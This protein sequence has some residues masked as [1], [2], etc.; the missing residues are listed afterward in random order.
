VSLEAPRDDVGIQRVD[1]RVRL[2]VVAEEQLLRLRRLLEPAAEQ[3]DELEADVLAEVPQL[4]RAE[5]LQLVLEDD[6]VVGHAVEVELGADR[7]ADL[8]RARGHE[9]RAAAS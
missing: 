4:A 8:R 2:P 9:E 7:L 6:A 1:E 3:R 5:V